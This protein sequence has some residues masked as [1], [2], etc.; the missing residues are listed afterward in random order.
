[1]RAGSCDGCGSAARFPQV[2]KLSLGRPIGGLAWLTSID[3]YTAQPADIR[4]ARPVGELS[5]EF[6]GTLTLVAFGDGLS[7]WRSP[8]PWVGQGRHVH[9]HLQRAG[10]WC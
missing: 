2:A 3:R 1:M 4:S 5:A 10:D 8:P 9:D 7:P 6:I